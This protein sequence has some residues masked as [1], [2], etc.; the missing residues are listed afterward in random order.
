MP[1]TCATLV[2]ARSATRAV[3][4]SSPAR[5]RPA[6]SSFV[7]SRLVPPAGPEAPPSSTVRPGSVGRTCMHR[8]GCVVCKRA[9]PGVVCGEIWIF[10]GESTVFTCSPHMMRTTAKPPDRTPI[11]LPWS[12]PEF[13]A[14]L[15]PPLSMPQRGPRCTLGSPRLLHL[16]LG[17]LSTGMPWKC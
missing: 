6:R 12:A 5:D 4:C 11:P 14:C 3:R 17:G 15:F 13:T 10:Q 16:S 8:T 1:G 7:E 2:A 9:Y